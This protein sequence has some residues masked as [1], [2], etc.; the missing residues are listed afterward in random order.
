MPR[1]VK[2]A[3]VQ[4]CPVYMDRDATVAKACALIA[5]VGAAGGELAVFPEAFIPGYPRWLWFIPARHTH[6]LRDL[7]AALVANAVVVPSDTTAHLPW[8]EPGMGTEEGLA[9]GVPA[10]PQSSG[11]RSPPRWKAIPYPMRQAPAQD[12]CGEG[13]RT[14]PRRASRD[15][16]TPDERSLTVTTAAVAK[17]DDVEGVAAT[18]T[19]EAEK[20][21]RI[22]R[23]LAARLREGG[24]VGTRGI[25]RQT[26][27]LPT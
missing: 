13:G 25:W 20:S 3:A 4:A 26:G 15:E 17:G 21:P 23:L 19:A 16:E 10:A 6:A 24:G 8:S 7:Y 27:G 11:Y 1:P 9:E 14:E 22:A 18:S 5:E 2:I 12:G